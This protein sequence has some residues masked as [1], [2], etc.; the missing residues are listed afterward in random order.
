MKWYQVDANEIF[1]ECKT[2]PEGLTAL[3]VE[4]RLNPVRPKQPARG[5]WVEPPEDSL[6]KMPEQ[7]SVIIEERIIYL[8]SLTQ[9]DTTNILWSLA[10]RC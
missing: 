10:V 3:E 1:A 8:H 2:R 7:S 6:E 5:N 4:E 9:R